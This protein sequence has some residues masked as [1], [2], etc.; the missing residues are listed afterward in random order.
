MK[1]SLEE[2]TTL[3]ERIIGSGGA[4]CPRC[5]GNMTEDLRRGH[6]QCWLCGTQFTEDERARP[7]PVP[8][9]A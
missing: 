6:W 7:V 5:H 3:Y 2:L 1:M 8:E 4:I 9:A